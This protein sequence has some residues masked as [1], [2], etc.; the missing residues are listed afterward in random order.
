MVYAGQVEE[1]WEERCYHLFQNLNCIPKSVPWITDNADEQ[2][3]VL[4]IGGILFV[5]PQ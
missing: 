5:C 3:R 4:L 1:I 2:L